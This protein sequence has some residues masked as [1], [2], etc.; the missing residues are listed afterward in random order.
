MKK[1]LFILSIFWINLTCKAQF[2]PQA[3]LPGSTAIH[4]DS[5]IIVAWATNCTLERGWLDIADTTLGKTSTG[6]STSTLGMADANVVSLGDGGAAILYFANPITNGNGFDFAVFENGFRNPADSNEAFLELA[7]VSVSN[8]GINYYPFAS[9]CHNDTTL[10][11]A[12]AGMYMDARKVHNLAGKYITYYGTPFDLDELSMILSLDVDNI[13][14][15]KIKDVVGSLA[16]NYCTRD[17]NNVIINDPYPTAFPIG[18]FDL[19]AVAVIHQKFPT[20][21][22]DIAAL[23]EIVFYPNPVRDY[24]NFKN[25]TALHSFKIYSVDGQLL[26][27]NLISEQIAIHNL[28]CGLYL[29]DLQ[30]KEGER[31]V[32]RFLKLCE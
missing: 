17:A 19:D 2:A 4:K 10:Q 27:D 16:K 30:T 1:V 15:V 21:I 8:D 11:I 12:G 20:V 13:H 22:R 14:Y 3:G 18:G 28:K 26:Q 29:L 23:H 9:A 7:A 31:M 24:I 6:D 25:I 32:Y 5:S